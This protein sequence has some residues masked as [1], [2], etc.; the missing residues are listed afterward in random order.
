M[1]Q[2]GERLVHLNLAVGKAAIMVAEEERHAQLRPRRRRWWIR[3]WISRR[4]LHGQYDQL[5]SELMREH[6][7]DFKAFIRVEPELFFELIQ[8]IGPRI[9]KS[10]K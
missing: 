5:M 7:K 2:V 8:R 6:P 10:T 3:P 1:D 4:Q 9:Q